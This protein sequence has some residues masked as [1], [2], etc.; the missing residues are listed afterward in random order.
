MGRIGKME[1]YGR[2]YEVLMSALREF[3][4][5]MWQ[6]KPAPEMWSIHETIVHIADSEANSYARCRR[7]IAEP[8]QS[9]MAYDE[10]RWASALDYHRQSTEEAL[11]LF[12]V[13]RRN[14]YHLI[15]DVPEA[16]WAHTILHPENGLMTMDDWLD[17][18]ERHVPEHIAQMRAVYE[19]WRAQSSAR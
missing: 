8:G 17:V 15:R 3:P 6:F 7:L 19:A 13:L 18:Y 1:T 9:V 2:A 12:R 5:E 10:N 16:V 11:E 4:A 14:S